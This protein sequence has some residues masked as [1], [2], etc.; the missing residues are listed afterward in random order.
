[1]CA[2]VIRQV[3]GPR[4]GHTAGGADVGADAGMCAHMYRQVAGL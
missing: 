1:M 4:E 3:A 2:H